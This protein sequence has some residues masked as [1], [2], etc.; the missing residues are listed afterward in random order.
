MLNKLRG[1][2]SF[3]RRKHTVPAVQ[4]VCLCLCVCACVHACVCVIIKY[5]SRR[6]LRRHRLAAF[7][8][9]HCFP[10]S[11]LNSETQNGLIMQNRFPGNQRNSPYEENQH[12][13]STSVPPTTLRPLPFQ[14]CFWQAWS[15]WQYISLQKIKPVFYWT[16]SGTTYPISLSCESLY[17]QTRPRSGR[18]LKPL[19]ASLVRG[20]IKPTWH[21]ILSP[22]HNEDNC[23][24]RA[25]HHG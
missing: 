21:I 7:T 11:L 3:W 12:Q 17:P 19:M 1:L 24:L 14:Y 23:L 15:L 9:H 20:L 10:P 4:C 6:T 5:C 25:V 22:S 2:N 16:S 18:Q 8:S 13:P